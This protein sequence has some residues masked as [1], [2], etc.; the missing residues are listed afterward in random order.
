MEVIAIENDITVFGN[1]VKDFPA[2]ISAAFDSLMK[3]LEDGK[4]RSYYGLSWM[5]GTK[6]VYYVLAP[7]IVK[8]EGSRLHMK[9]F[10]MEKGKYLAVRINDWKKKLSSIAAV[11]ETIMKDERIESGAP[12]WE[13][14]F[15]DDE[16]LCLMKM[17][18]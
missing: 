16:M 9:L 8:D 18:A 1:L 5:E 12:C 15:S 2:G 17:K 10:T 13:W 6:I 4:K 3:Q 14:Y 7:E 11:F